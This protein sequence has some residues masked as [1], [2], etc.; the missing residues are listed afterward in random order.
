MAKRKRKTP[1]ARLRAGSA[2]EL[3]ILAMLRRPRG[4]TT[5]EMMRRMKYASHSVRSV[6]SNLR[7]F[8][9]IKIARVFDSKRGHV[10]RAAPSTAKE[11]K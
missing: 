6:V 10:Y 3:K 9:G 7:R 1:R 2:P 8:A 5:A 11:G 4:A